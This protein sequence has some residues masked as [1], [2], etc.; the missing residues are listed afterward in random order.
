MRWNWEE[1][2]S[3]RQLLYGSILF[4]IFVSRLPRKSKQSGL[5]KSEKSLAKRNVTRVLTVQAVQ[6]WWFKEAALSC[7]TSVALSILLYKD[8]ALAFHMVDTILKNELSCT[9]ALFFAI[10]FVNACCN[11]PAGFIQEK[12]IQHHVLNP[13]TAKCGQRQ[14]STKFPNFI[15]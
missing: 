13:F 2:R 8:A 4:Q 7:R 15:F 9:A 1:D 12:A 11:F 6:V 3:G 5:S 14:I 10:L